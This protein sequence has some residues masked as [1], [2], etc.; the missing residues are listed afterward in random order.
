MSHPLPL[1]LALAPNT[2]IYLLGIGIV[3]AMI[4]SII[5]RVL[6]K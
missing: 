3:G 5:L 2:W 4:I 1:V 6:R